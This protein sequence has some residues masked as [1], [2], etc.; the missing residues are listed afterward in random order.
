MTGKDGSLTVLIAE[1]SPTQAE[2][3]RHLLEERGYAV[4]VASDG[5][6]A[7]EAARSHKPTLIISDIVMPEMD[8]YEL[9]RAIKGDRV[10]QD[11]PVIILTVL[12]SM[13]EIANSLECGADHFVRKPYDS[14]NLLSRIDYILSNR[15][16]RKGRRAQ[17]GLEIY[18]AGKKHF[19]T[20]ER[21][22]ILDLLLSSYEEAIRVNE[23]LKLRAA[24]LEAANRELESFSY[25]VSHDLR[26]PLRAIDGFSR[27]LEESCADRLEDEDRRV[28][29]T[30]RDSARRMN[31]LVDDLLRLSQVARVPLHVRKIDMV[32]LAREAVEELR[33]ASAPVACIVQPLPGARGDPSLIRQ[34]WINLLSNAIKYSAGREDPVVQVSGHAEGG[35][36]VYCVKDNGAGFDMRHYAKLFGV[37]QRLHSA[38]EFAG[39]GIGLSIVQRV[40]SR[41]GG[42][43]WAEGKV[44]AGASFCFA[45]PREGGA[46]DGARE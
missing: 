3:L 20:S 32:A 2:Q 33:A 22:Q 45:L 31:Q 26:S 38:E 30:I 18:L 40:V 35:E 14:A 39:T 4:T 36:S 8:G 1:D 27:I 5:K 34:V 11:V 13:Q 16:L 7:L 29:R 9:C 21:E 41:H 25:S 10:L 19:I 44:D 37:F 15:E 46:A 24:Q 28:L 23:E 12:S 17:M 6:K 43:V 42:R